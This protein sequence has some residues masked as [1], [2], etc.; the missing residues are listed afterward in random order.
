MNNL[1]TIFPNLAEF[2]QEISSAYKGGFKSDNGYRMS[3]IMPLYTFGHHVGDNYF[4]LEKKING[5][6]FSFVSK[7]GSSEKVITSSHEVYKD[8]SFEEWNK[9]IDSVLKRHMQKPEYIKFAT[10]KL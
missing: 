10:G 3:F 9:L 2:L 8:L 6:I 4:E 1:K 7:K 5:Y